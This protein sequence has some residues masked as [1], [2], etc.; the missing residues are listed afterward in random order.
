MYQGKQEVGKFFTLSMRHMCRGGG[1]FIYTD[2]Q[3]DH[4]VYILYI[5]RHKDNN[6]RIASYHKSHSI[7]SI[8]YVP[9]VHISYRGVS[10]SHLQ[11]YESDT[12]TYTRTVIH[13]TR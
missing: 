10:S 9:P 2:V 3:E 12:T 13:A 7:S 1:L 4:G 6:L 5:A 11:T 8:L